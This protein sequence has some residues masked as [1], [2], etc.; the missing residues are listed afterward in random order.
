[1][2]SIGQNCLSLNEYNPKVDLYRI[3]TWIEHI[4]KVWGDWDEYAVRNIGK[5]KYAEISI[6]EILPG[7]HMDLHWMEYAG[8]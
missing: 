3:T 6:F 2:S 1:M 5:R 8:I 4:P 7:L